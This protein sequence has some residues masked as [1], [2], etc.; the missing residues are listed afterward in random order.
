[1]K[2]NVVATYK[3]GFEGGYGG[4][5]YILL[6]CCFY[7]RSVYCLYAFLLVRK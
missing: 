7:Q 1:M 3:N 6:K 4:H 2:D 5:I